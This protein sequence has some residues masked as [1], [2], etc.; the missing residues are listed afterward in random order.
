[1]VLDRR[2]AKL[3]TGKTAR[4][5]ALAFARSRTEKLAAAERERADEFEAIL[6]AMFLMAAVDGEVAADEVGQLAASLQAIVDTTGGKL[7]LDIGP[8][9]D[10]LAEHL[11]RDGW[12]ARL[13]TLAERLRSEESRS[14]AFRLAAAVA[15]VDDNVVHAEAAAIDALAAA[16]GIGGDESQRILAEVQDELFG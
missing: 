4:E 5:T 16:L 13:D 1:M 15:F 14:F 8:T 9:L 3:V 11:R 10:A 2:I 6:E 12:K 7:Q